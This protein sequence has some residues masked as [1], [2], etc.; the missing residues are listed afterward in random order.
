MSYWINKLRGSP[1]TIAHAITR[2]IRTSTKSR[3]TTQRSDVAFEFGRSDAMGAL[4]HVD[5]VQSH[6]VSGKRRAKLQQG[7]EKQDKTKA[8]SVAMQGV[9]EATA[10]DVCTILNSALETPAFSRIFRG[11]E[12]TSVAF[13]IDRVKLSPDCS[14]AVAYWR[15]HLMDKFIS[16]AVDREGVEQGQLLSHK[17]NKYVTKRFQNREPAF[18]SY[19]L[20][21][22]D[23]RRVPRIAFKHFDED[24]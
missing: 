13:E 17:M 3:S 18:R 16:H 7:L 6:L 11:C 4:E 22:M 9:L 19:L 21:N 8:T 14:H 1:T 5:A 15:S 20:K 12:D 23:F 10:E 2:C 24:Q